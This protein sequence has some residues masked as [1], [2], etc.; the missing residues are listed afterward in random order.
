M[1][2]VRDIGPVVRR[3]GILKF[4]TRVW[5]EV[6]DDNLFPWAASLAYSWMFAIF[7]FL[8]VLLSLLPHLPEYMKEEAYADVDG[9][10]DQIMPS[11]A[12]GILKQQVHLVLNQPH[13]GGLLSISLLVAIW[14]ASGGMAMTMS[15]LDKAYD[16]EHPRKFY[17][18]RLIAIL[19][20]IIVAA[21]IVAVMILLPVGTAVIHWFQ[22]LGP[23]KW[24]LNAVRYGIALLF[25][26]T[27]LALIYYFGPSHRRRFVFLTP[28]SLFCVTVW[29]LLGL[30]FR[31]YVNRYAAVSYNKTYGAVAGVA[32]LLLFFYIDA[33]VLLAGAE[34][35]AEV[36][37]ELRKEPR[38]SPV[39]APP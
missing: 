29:V 28:G 9:V 4:V 6:G 12:G 24:A 1:P 17:K 27:V 14:A 10:I 35:N 36:E 19:L 32:I 5:R 15:A 18:H 11:N 16:V 31:L 13:T 22:I 8:I 34:I 25:M 26:L 3:V 2:R 37:A 7:P 30:T 39:T 21:L 23:L 20:T 33:L 38:P